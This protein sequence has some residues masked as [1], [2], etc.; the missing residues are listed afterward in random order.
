MLEVG[1]IATDDTYIKLQQAYD[2]VEAS[3]RTL[4]KQTLA[5]RGKIDDGTVKAATDMAKTALMVSEELER[6]L[7]AD[8]TTVKDNELRQVLKNAGAN[9]Q[10]I[11]LKEL[12]I[13][14]LH[15]TFCKKAMV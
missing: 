10:Q 12:E 15:R 7:F 4:K 2:A 9:Y 5:L 6:F 11:R 8:R 1:L 3:M 13:K 14:S